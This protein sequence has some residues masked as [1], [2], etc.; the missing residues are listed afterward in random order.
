MSESLGTLAIAG[1]GLMGGSLGLAARRRGLAGAVVGYARREETR[2]RALALG[3]VD[4]VAAD[5]AAAVADADLAVFCVPIFAVCELIEQCAP[6]LRAGSIV[7]DVGSTKAAIA[8]RAEAA[9]AGTAAAF[10]GSHP[11]AGSDRDG[12][13][14]ADAEL[15]AGATVIVTAAAPT[16]AAARRVIAFWEALG[17]A[18]AV[19]TPAVHDRIMARTSHLPHLMAATLVAQVCGGGDCP[20]FCGPGFRDTTRVAGGHAGVWTDIVVS[21]REAIA[22]ELAGFSTGVA[23]LRRLV[24]S[25]DQEAIHAFLADVRRRRRACTA[26]PGEGGAPEARLR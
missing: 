8:A 2:R 15:Y 11:I 22:A 14:A 1:L 25:G 18:T 3:A 6:H 21:N 13:E 7:T 4:R 12:I 23:A 10:V 9:L 20:R 26:D 17:A 19:M 5:P 16:A 24:E